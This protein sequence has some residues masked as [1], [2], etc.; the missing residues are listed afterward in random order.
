[1]VNTL[2]FNLY[3]LIQYMYTYYNHARGTPALP[4]YVQ[5]A[6]NL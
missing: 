5:E 1:M 3:H 2:E 6:L 4:K